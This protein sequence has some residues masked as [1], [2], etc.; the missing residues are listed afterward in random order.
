MAWVIASRSDDRTAASS[1]MLAQS[2]ADVAR[3]EEERRK[4][5]PAPTKVYT[6]KDLGAAAGP[7]AAAV[8]AAAG[9]AAAA[10]AATV[11][12]AAP[13]AAAAG[14]PPGARRSG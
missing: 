5:V 3:Q 14:G 4:S 12:R 8:V 10:A 1:R 6:N 9:P 11:E 2:L 13:Q 7:A